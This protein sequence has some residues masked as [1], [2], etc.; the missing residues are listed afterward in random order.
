MYTY[1]HYSTVHSPKG[2]ND[3]GVHQQM[4]EQQNVESTHKRILLGIK[5]NEILTCYN[6]DESRKHYQEKARCKGTY[7]RIPYQ[8]KCPE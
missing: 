3:R 6:V 1:G 5:R 8:W 7:C 4:N 2:G